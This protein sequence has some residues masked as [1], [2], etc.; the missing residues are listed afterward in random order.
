MNTVR[1]KT[2]G[3]ACRSRTRRKLP[4]PFDSDDKL[5]ESAVQVFQAR[6]DQVEAQANPDL[7]TKQRHR[8]AKSAADWTSFWHKSFDLT[9]S[10]TPFT[11]K[12]ADHRLNKLEREIL[13]ALL[14]HQ[15]AMTGDEL[16]TCKKLLWFLG[17]THK[18]YIP[19][20]RAL[21]EQERLFRAKL[22]TFDDPESDLAIRTPTIDAA[23]V[24]TVLSR[25]KQS[26]SSWKVKKEEQLFDHLAAL[27]QALTKKSE[28]LQETTFSGTVNHR[29]QKWDRQVNRL[30]HRLDYTL[31]DHPQW[32][33]AEIHEELSRIDEFT[34][35]L[36]LLGKYLGHLDSQD[37]LFTGGG[38]AR[39]V[40]EDPLEVISRLR[41]L[42]ADGNLSQ[43]GWICPCGGDAE[44]A[45]N[46]AGSLEQMEFELA[47]RAVGVLGIAKQTIRNR[48]GDYH[49]RR[50]TLRLDQLA[51]SGKVRQALDMAIIHARLGKRLSDD[52][53][54]GEII[55]YGR[56]PVLLFF[57]SPG[58]GKTATAE[59]VAQTLD[60]SIL[61]A[62]YSRIQNCYVGQTEKNIVRAFHE[63]KK[64]DAVLFWD[65]ADAMFYDRDSA[66][67]NWEVRDVNVLLQQLE[68]FE[69]VCILAT[70]RKITLDKALE[71][72]ISLKIE[73]ERP[74]VDE[75]RQ[76]WQKFLPRKLP[77]A[78]DVNLDRISEA[79]LAG[80]EIKNV[81]L[82]AA[83]LA[84]QRNEQGPVAMQDFQTAIDM[85]TANRWNVAG[86]KKIGFGN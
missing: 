20:M 62:D 21:S 54:L 18:Q 13:T 86:R 30:L 11:K 2:E 1:T 59:G 35:F 17:L 63:A 40:S 9:A 39:A 51:L 69:G 50:A 32:K 83:R 43:K 70:N 57:G 3:V 41:L 72:R 14:L 22:F 74:G 77:L 49:A 8:L 7:S 10:A 52:W 65:E 45:A 79:D 73:F 42:A 37:D 81:V 47:S 15:L 48:P 34:I 29:A 4:A 61:V 84:L 76:I 58:T 56:S 12:C 33:L 71:R 25:G 5:L 82:N 36:A 60:K 28:A 68:L 24:E 64:Q 16:H 26:E 31:Q 19:A 67:Y 38:L 46:D 55:P 75:R 23:L 53:G 44:F 85:E 66:R 80:G 27:T 6:R 78:D